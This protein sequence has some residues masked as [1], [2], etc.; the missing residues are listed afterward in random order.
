MIW[1][2]WLAFQS[3]QK[4]IE[5]IQG[6]CTVSHPK[7]LA[8]TPTLSLSHLQTIQFHQ[9]HTPIE[10]LLAAHRDIML[11]RPTLAAP[12]IFRQFTSTYLFVK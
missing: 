12:E 6:E 2:H 3:T 11:F 4:I 5:C 8:P 9:L 1:S 10:I 7:T